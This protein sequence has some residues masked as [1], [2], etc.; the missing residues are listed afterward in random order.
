MAQDKDPA[1]AG[2]LSIDSNRASPPTVAACAD[3]WE[4]AGVVPMMSAP[5]A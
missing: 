1:H 2:A 4:E 3:T 5:P